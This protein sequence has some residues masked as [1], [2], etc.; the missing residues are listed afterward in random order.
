[1]STQWHSLFFATATIFPASSFGQRTRWTRGVWLE[2]GA[3]P[4]GSSAATSAWT[5]SSLRPLE[6]QVRVALR[7][8]GWGKSPGFALLGGCTSLGLFTKD[9]HHPSS[10]AVDTSPAS[11]PHTHV[12]PSFHPLKLLLLSLWPLAGNVSVVNSDMGATGTWPGTP[13]RT[14]FYAR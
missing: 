5:P 1:M 4:C 3:A 13:W 2:P 10:H 12:A 11:S 6:W 8:W 7:T 9:K 14:Q